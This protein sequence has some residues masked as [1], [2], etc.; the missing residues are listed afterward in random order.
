MMTG[1]LRDAQYLAP[2]FLA[3][4]KDLCA[5]PGCRNNWTPGAQRMIEKKK[6]KTRLMVIS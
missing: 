1:V 4:S 6:K 5:Q 3:L 2:E